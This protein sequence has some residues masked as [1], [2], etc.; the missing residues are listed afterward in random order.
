MSRDLAVLLLRLSGLGLPW[1][2]PELALVY[3]LAF[4]TIALLGPGWFSLDA[5]LGLK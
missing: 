2:N 3:L 1:G 4:V 5:R